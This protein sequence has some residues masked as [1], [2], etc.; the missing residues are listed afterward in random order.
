MGVPADATAG[1]ERM[2][3]SAARPVE[4]ID[5]TVVTPAELNVDVRVP[6]SY[7]AEAQG[8]D[9][10]PNLEGSLDGIARLSARHVRCV[11]IKSAKHFFWKMFSVRLAKTS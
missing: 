3:E 8:R 9:V 4:R 7:L 5:V 11:V 10:T 6:A 1:K 2:R